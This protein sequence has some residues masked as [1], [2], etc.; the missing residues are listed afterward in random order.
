YLSDRPTPYAV[1]SSKGK[2]L[3]YLRSSG[4]ENPTSPLF[5][6]IFLVLG[7][8]FSTRW[9][10]EG[11][12][13][14]A[15]RNGVFMGLGFLVMILFMLR[16]LTYTYPDLL[17]LRH[18]ELFSPE[19]YQGGVWLNSLGDLLINAFLLLW[20]ALFAYRGFRDW[21]MK[22]PRQLF[23]RTMITLLLLVALV[24]GTFQMAAVVQSLVTDAEISFKVTDFFSLN[25]YSFVAFLILATLGVSYFLLAQILLR[26]LRA[27]WPWQS[28]LLYVLM[29]TLGLALLTFTRDT[30]LI[31]L[32]LMVLIWL[33]L[34][35]LLLNSRYLSGVKFRLNISELLFWLFFFSFSMAAVIVMENRKYEQGQRRLFAQKLSQQAEPSNERLLNIALTY[36]DQDFLNQQFDRFTHP[37][38]NAQL[39]DSLL[40]KNFNAFLNAFDTRIYVFDGALTP[41]PLF[42][43][44]PATFETLNTI[45]N[46]QGKETS[47]PDLRYF[48]RSFD[49]FSY[50]SRK[51]VVHPGDQ[52]IRGY[53]FVLAEPRRYKKDALV[54]ALFRQSREAL[55]PEYSSSYA[56]AVYLGG[57]LVDHYNHYEFPTHLEPQQ[58]PVSEYELRRQNDYVELWYRKTKNNVVI[59]AK[60]DNYFLESI[61]LFAYFFTLFLL[62]IAF[63]GLGRILVQSRLR[64]TFFRDRFRFSIRN[65]IH[66]TIIAV[67]LISFIVIGASTILFFI[68]RY[69]TSN[70]EV[71]SRNMQIM[72]NQM[73]NKLKEEA[74]SQRNASTANAEGKLVQLM[75]ELSEIHG[76]DVNLFDTTGQLQ[77]ASRPLIYA[78]GVLSTLMNPEA[79]YSLHLRSAVQSVQNER[80]GKVDYISMY[81]PLRDPEGTV[82]GYLNV[83]SYNTQGD[84]RQEISNFIVTLIN[85]NAFIFLIAGAISLLI[86]NRITLSFSLIGRKM[87]DINLGRMNQEISWD[88]QDE[89]GQ[90]VREYNKMVTKLD[91]S[92]AALAKSERES[93]WRQMARQV[94]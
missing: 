23:V 47:I 87:Q 50:I 33:L 61:T 84:L 46:N 94:A 25:V 90:L 89:I 36:L 37:I 62:L 22:F 7:T 79:W 21:P 43:E 70:Q 54:P 60:K 32:N 26:M 1:L 27:C 10:Q 2:Q 63:Y 40:N 75:Q 56:Y 20:I 35:S 57:E 77:V 71:L 93:A 34:F 81:N 53:L 67:S 8:L 58:I 18:F 12:T 85:L 30:A 17:Q 11:A 44:D 9:I 51:E 6:Y 31:E 29:S 92:A 91:E 24:R 52:V 74:A 5:F 15:Q 64:W 78:K 16:A 82:I 39:K 68:S 66:S 76:T 3:F 69:R 48:E 14:L 45:Y 65:Q 55:L 19:I 80:M 13:Q 38:E 88:R 83:P 41:Q 28:L 86:T 72:V 59:I 73:Q 49:R 4:T 42:N